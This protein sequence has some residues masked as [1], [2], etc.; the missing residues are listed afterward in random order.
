MARGSRHQQAEQ[1]QSRVKA[2]VAILKEISNTSQLYR[3]VA[4]SRHSPHRAAGSLPHPHLRDAPEPGHVQQSALLVSLSDKVLD[5]PHVSR[6]HRAAALAKAPGHLGAYRW[7]APSRRAQ[8]RAEE[9]EH[10]PLQPGPSH[11]LACSASLALA[12]NAGCW[13]P[14]PHGQNIMIICQMKGRAKDLSFLVSFPSKFQGGGS[15][16]C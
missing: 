4:C 7:A 1:G 10:L 2:P 3:M 12:A 13:V 5:R 16:P 15:V 11:H 14:R 8:E 6:A 9:R